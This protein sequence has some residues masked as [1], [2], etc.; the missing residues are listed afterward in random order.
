MADRGQNCRA[1]TTFVTFVLRAA[2]M[3]AEKKNRAAG[4]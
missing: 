4:K 1:A 3:A 2:G